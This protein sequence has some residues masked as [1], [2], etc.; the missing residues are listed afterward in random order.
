MNCLPNEPVPPVIKTVLL[1]NMFSP[2]VY[3]LG[4]P[5]NEVEE[6]NKVQ[7]GRPVILQVYP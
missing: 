6:H 7:H 3:D 4:L 5:I 1:F 2:L